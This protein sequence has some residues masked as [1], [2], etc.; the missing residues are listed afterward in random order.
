M[1][2]LPLE[3]DNAA[4]SVSRIVMCDVDVQQSLDFQGVLRVDPDGAHLT[5]VEKD[6]FENPNGLCFS[7][8]ESLLYVN[9]TPRQHIRVFD[10]LADG[11]TT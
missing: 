5:V 7:P 1:E 8:D 6:G 3:V 11:T 9:D 4:P 2:L 10:V